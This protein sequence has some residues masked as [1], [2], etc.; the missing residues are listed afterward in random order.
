MYIVT[1]DTVSIQPSWL[2]LDMVTFDKRGHKIQD[3]LIINA[4][5][6]GEGKGG[7]TFGKSHFSRTFDGPIC[8][9]KYSGHSH[10]PVIPKV[11]CYCL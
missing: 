5:V 2:T 6:I 4:P 9:L 7:G 8:L 11:P 3:T 10:S 1:I